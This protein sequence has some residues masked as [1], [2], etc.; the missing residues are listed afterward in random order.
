MKTHHHVHVEYEIRH[1]EHV[2]SVL[3]PQDYIPISYWRRRLRSLDAATAVP[4][5]LARLRRLERILESLE[6]TAS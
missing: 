6:Q 5:L 3:K 1:L 2:F 4:D